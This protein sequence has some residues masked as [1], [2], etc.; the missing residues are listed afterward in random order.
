[1]KGD[2]FWCQRL[3]QEGFTNIHQALLERFSGGGQ[4]HKPNLLGND[5]PRH[6]GSEERLLGQ[7]SSRVQP[8]YLIAI[9]ATIIALSM[10]VMTNINGDLDFWF[11][12]KARMLLGVGLPLIFVPIL[13]ASYDGIPKH[14]TDQSRSRTRTAS[15]RMR[16]PQASRIR[17]RCSS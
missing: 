16:T 7:L 6:G 1:L 9:G 17:R 8:K 14:K 4:L 12:A 15:R 5:I 2:P 11:F 13:S 10:Y 3:L